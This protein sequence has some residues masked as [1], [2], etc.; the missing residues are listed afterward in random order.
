MS[1]KEKLKRARTMGEVLL[2]LNMPEYLPFFEK[3]NIL[4][5]STLKL[6]REIDLKCIGIDNSG[7]K[8]LL[9]AVRYLSKNPMTVGDTIRRGI[10]C[11]A[12]VESRDPEINEKFCLQKAED[13]LLRCKVEL[14][15][16]RN[17]L[18]RIQ[19][20]AK[21]IREIFE[22][23]GDAREY[24]QKLR[25]NCH[26]CGSLSIQRLAIDLESLLN[27]IFL[28]NANSNPSNLKPLK[29]HNT[30][31]YCSNET[32]AGPWY[33]KILKPTSVQGYKQPPA[34][35]YYH[36][37][38]EDNTYHETTAI[39]LPTSATSQYELPSLV[40]GLFLKF[41]K[42]KTSTPHKQQSSAVKRYSN[43]SSNTRHQS[44]VRC[45][46]QKFLRENINV[47]LISAPLPQKS[48]ELFG[49][50]L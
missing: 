38:D 45:S 13:E 15:L 36:S 29:R 3:A 31:L 20:Q 35:I 40:D 37:V 9:K 23:T 11:A 18:V 49:V 19:K 22:M 7:R 46:R 25:K 17:E 4:Q 41:G 43:N 34:A 1:T 6:L 28:P 50:Q 10:Q 26:T 44:F 32:G 2:I 33:T 24:V 16:K 48:N 21:L 47:L 39:S 42:N 14:N 27:N 5:A 12:N 8:K 30:Q